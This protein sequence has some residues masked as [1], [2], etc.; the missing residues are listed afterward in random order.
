MIKLTSYRAADACLSV[1]LNQ[2][3]V[4]RK[5][6]QG[7]SFVVTIGAYLHIGRRVLALQWGRP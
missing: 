7:G 6:F 3:R 2:Y 4:V 1:G 5:D